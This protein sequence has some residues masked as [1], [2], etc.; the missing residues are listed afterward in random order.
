MTPLIRDHRWRAALALVSMAI[1]SPG[2]TATA[3]TGQIR[4]S[5]EKSTGNVNDDTQLFVKIAIRKAP[6]TLIS[7][8]RAQGTG[9]TRNYDN[10]HWVLS[11]KVHIEH[12]NAVLD[13]DTATVV[14]ANGLIQSIEVQ[15]APAKFSHP[16]S[17][18]GQLFNGTADTIAFDG[19]RR[20]VR[21][22]GR[23]WFSRAGV[24]EGNSGRQLVYNI[25]SR[26]L[27]SATGSDP[28]APISVVF[29]GDNPIQGRFDGSFSLGTGDDTV[30]GEQVTI[31]RGEGTLVTADRAQGSWSGTV[32][33]SRWVVSGKVHIEHDRATVD[34]DS[35]TIVFVDQLIRS[36]E[37]QGAPAKFFHPG[38]AAGRPFNGS[39]Q[40][41]SF[42]GSRRQVRFTGHILFSYG[43]GT[44]NSEKPL[45]YDLDIG[46]LH[47]ER[48]QDLPPI[49]IT[50]PKDR[51]PTPRTP[52]RS[53]A[54]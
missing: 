13:A 25:D 3:P 46:S 21:F 32:A 47:N 51:V 52:D 29:S 50:I 19:A 16:G 54:Q 17:S 48:N 6:G 31:T 23:P 44:G 2:M 39:A 36:I 34:A 45:I 5:S 4:V 1:L 9:I 10:S 15:G 18:E 28:V 53:S 38:K 12:D 49:G 22:A 40:A 43:P 7:A 35:A 8:D 42:D 33:N 26:A 24:G 41:I 30:S 20:E 37:V 11:G 14:F 27:Q